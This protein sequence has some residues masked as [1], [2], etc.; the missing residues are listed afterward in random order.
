VI[1][2][3]FILT[4]SGAMAGGQVT[5][6]APKPM[7]KTSRKPVAK[8]VEMLKCKPAGT[9]EENKVRE[10]AESLN[11]SDHE[12]LSRLIFS[13]ALSTGYWSKRCN[14]PSVESLMEAIAWGVM[15]RVANYSPNRDDPKPDA[16]FHVIFAQKQ[17]ST[18][19][20][21]YNDNPFAKAF[22]CPLEARRYLEKVESTE[23]AYDI[24]TKAKETAA[25]VLV[26]YQQSGIPA[27]FA[28][29]THFFYGYSEF[30]G[31]A[32]PAW[33]K[34]PDPAKNKGYVQLISGEKPCAE[35]Y[36]R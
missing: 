29:I 34:D 19:F 13:E 2:L 31:G 33:A 26:K 15:N 23:E 25:G 36:R 28:N 9:K 3:L 5:V 7:V 10:A 27:L 24:Y 6:P 32:R 18:S 20:S 8:P 4:V 1:G 12:V 21:S 11:L 22:L 35:F 30:G 14:A 16:I 17:F